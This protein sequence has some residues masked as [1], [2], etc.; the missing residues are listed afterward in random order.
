M[1]GMFLICSVYGVF[2]HPAMFYDVP[3]VRSLTTEAVVGDDQWFSLDT[4]IIL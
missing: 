1:S 4:D 2:W 3:F